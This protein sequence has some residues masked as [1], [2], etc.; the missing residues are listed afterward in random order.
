MLQTILLLYNVSLVRGNG[1]G[2]TTHQSCTMLTQLIIRETLDR[3]VYL[4]DLTNIGLNL[5]A[6]L[7]ALRAKEE[8]NYITYNIHI[9][10]LY[11]LF[12]LFIQQR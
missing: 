12:R 4:L 7:I 1:I 9:I 5:L 2:D 3:G 10:L 6:I 8:F 11:F